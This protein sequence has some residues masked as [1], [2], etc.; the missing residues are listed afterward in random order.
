ML[1]CRDFTSLIIP[2]PLLTITTLILYMSG[3]DITPAMS[4][5]NNMNSTIPSVKMIY[6]NHSYDMLPF[7]VLNE[8]GVKKLNFPHLPDQYK[9]EVVMASDKNFTFQ[10][11]KTP[12]EINAFGIDYEADTTEVTPLTKTGKNQFTFGNVHGILT[13]EVRSIYDDGSY[14]TYTCLVD[15]KNTAADG[16]QAKGLDIFA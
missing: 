6:A 8:E 14:V 3:L 15:I 9:P 7:I 11:S 12:R 4:A 1:V 16:N 10:F 5:T 2:V 13:L